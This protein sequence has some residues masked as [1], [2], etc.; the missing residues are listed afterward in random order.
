MQAESNFYQ[1][2]QKR[3]FILLA[4]GLGST[5]LGLVGSLVSRS[6]L[7]RQFWLQAVAWGGIDAAI[8]GFGLKGQAQKIEL[9]A[10]DQIEP[11][12]L[13]KDVSSY[14][15]ILLINVFLDV[16]YVLSGEA[17]RRWAKAARREDRQ[18]IGAGFIV[19]GLFLFGYDLFLTLEVGQGWLK[20]I[21][22][23]SARN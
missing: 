2:Q 19:Q 12:T 10:K 7:G 8:A 9:A 18:G 13:A 17:L 16:G 6:K 5:L 20:R 3:T 15:R 11:A 4:W 1:Y 21:T 23:A 22:K 14:H